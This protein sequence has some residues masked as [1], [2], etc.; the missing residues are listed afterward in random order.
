VVANPGS[1]SPNRLA[2]IGSL[3]QLPEA[4][5][6]QADATV[7]CL[8]RACTFDGA[9]SH[10]A[11]AVYAWEL[12]DGLTSTDARAART[13]PRD[14]SY[15]VRLSI[16]DASGRTSSTADTVNVVDRLPTAGLTGSCVPVRRCTLSAGSTSDDGRIVAYSWDFGDGTTGRGSSATYKKSY[17]AYGTYTTRV[18]VT[19]DAGQTSTTT[20]QLVVQPA[21]PVVVFSVRCSSG[22]T[23]NFDGRSSTAEGGVSGF[24]WEF[25]DG[26]VATGPTPIHQ[27]SGAG[28]YSAR[29]TVRGTLGTSATRTLQLVLR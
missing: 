19:D 10:G 12:G 20:R 24:T 23:C 27:Y 2:F 21:A 18:T 15:V 8:R 1:S 22:R 3:G 14:G 11:V 13:Y 7:S 28:T 5:V 16:R 9:A 4:G 17:A 29:L 6:L 25:G 26:K